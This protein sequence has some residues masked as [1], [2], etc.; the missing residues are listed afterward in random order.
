MYKRIDIHDTG[1]HPGD[2][3]RANDSAYDTQQVSLRA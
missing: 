1:C 3:R 2:T